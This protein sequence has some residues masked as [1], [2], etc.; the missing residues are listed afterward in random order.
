MLEKKLQ[1]FLIKNNGYELRRIDKELIFLESEH[2]FRGGRID[3][4]ASK[5]G[6]PVA[7]ELKAR[8]YSSSQ[9][10]GQ[11]IN[12]HN[13][14][15]SKQGLVYLVAPKIKPGIIS[16]LNNYDNMKFFEF[17][18]K[19][20]FYEIKEPSKTKR[21]I[22]EIIL[23]DFEINIIQKYVQIPIAKILSKGVKKTMGF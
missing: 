8:D 9:V 11:M 5:N 20:R 15:K 22:K 18:E 14:L 17:D 10:A 23:P 16:T 12:Y 2:K 1:E 6:L 13:Y 7:I 21:I 4:L 3:I 19:L